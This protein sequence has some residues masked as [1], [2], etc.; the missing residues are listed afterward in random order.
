MTPDDD[1]IAKSEERT[2][3]KIKS[4]VQTLRTVIEEGGTTYTDEGMV[5]FLRSLLRDLEFL[6]DADPAPVTQWTRESIDA[7]IADL[8]AQASKDA[9]QGSLTPYRL[10]MKKL[11]DALLLEQQKEN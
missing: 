5:V 11:R 7:V 10:G 6:L 4:R 9:R 8:C 3:T 2:I 1:V